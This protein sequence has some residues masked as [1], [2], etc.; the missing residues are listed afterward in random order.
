MPPEIPAQNSDRLCAGQRVGPYQILEPIGAGGMGE[1]YSARDTRLDRTVALKILPSDFATDQHRMRRFIQ[2]GKAASAINHPN[3]CTIYDVGEG[4][5]RRPFIAME[6]IEGQ[7]LSARI[8]RQPLK[9]EEIIEVAGQ[10][11]DAL[12]A[13]CSKGIT[14]R[15]IKPGNIMITG[16][17]QVKVL[18]FGLARVAGVATGTGAES[19]TLVKTDSGAL[20]G[21]VQYM[22]PE[23]ALGQKVDHRSDI[24]SLGIVMYEMATGRAPF[25]GSNAAEILD[26]IVH[27]QP[28][29]IARF[30]Y[31][32]PPELERIIRKCLEKDPG[33]RYQSARETL[34]DLKSLKRDCGGARA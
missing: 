30:N 12:D 8:V 17:G 27:A 21:T 11:A 33:S 32:T 22:S 26:R 13:A 3:V 28:E 2:E 23:Q 4:E 31:E 24:F 34:I 20:L 10:V 25:A 16:R 29:A 9:S 6:Y 14:H 18:D 5:N 1:V 15:D 19:T 7:T